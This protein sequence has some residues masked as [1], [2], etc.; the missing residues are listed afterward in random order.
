ML[1]CSR[2][3]A[4]GGKMGEWE[5]RVILDRPLMYTQSRWLKRITLSVSLAPFLCV[6]LLNLFA[7][8]T[9]QNYCCNSQIKRKAHLSLPHPLPWAQVQY[10]HRNNI[11][12]ATISFAFQTVSKMMSRQWWMAK[13]LNSKTHK[14]TT[15]TQRVVCDQFLAFSEIVFYNPTN[16]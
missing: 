15:D 10:L 5:W 14:Q 13:T 3:G 9:V 2:D 8:H 6:C 7:Y 11:A 12:L 1:C 4:P 16:L